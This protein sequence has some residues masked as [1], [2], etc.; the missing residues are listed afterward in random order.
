MVS[1]SLALGPFH[2]AWRGPQR[3]VLRL[4]GEQIADIE[5]QDGFNERGCAE[6]VPRLDLPQALQLVTR[7]CGAC[8]FAHSL[9]FCQAIEQ[10]CG[11]AV[12][13]SAALLRCVAAELERLGSHLR[14]AAAVLRAL[15]M[16]LRAD[17]L[18]AMREQ[19]VEGLHTM[20][21]ARVIPDLCLPG[22][23][24]RDLPPRAREELLVMLPK[25]NRALYRFVDGI[26]DHR[27]LLARTIEVGALPRAAAEQFGVRGPLARASGIAHDTRA[28]QPY[29]GY[30]R[31]DVR[32]IT[33]EGGDLY[34]RL[35][36]LLLEAYE[37][38][39]LV[40]QGLE[41]LPEGSAQG[42]IPDT[43]KAGQGSGSAE[44]PRGMIRYIVESDGRRITSARIDAP[45]QLDRLLART[46]LSG[47]LIDNAVAIIVSTDH[48]TACAER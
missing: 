43:L 47:A 12:T 13:D 32:P 33:Q 9:A 22:G 27:A 41:R 18:E 5:Y 42:A 15:G 8:S 10:L 4:S 2:P 7:I 23:L 48:C 31:L 20:G 30:A 26:I 11:I 1:Y 34:A 36:L 45:R 21:G 24:R 17:A 19:A 25:L 28:D 37:S 16:E 39:K 46:L 35:M 29:A 44:G 40:E 14:A 6:R 3:F 38:T